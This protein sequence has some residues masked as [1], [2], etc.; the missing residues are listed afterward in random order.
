[1]SITSFVK[2]AI[3]TV[4]KISLP[5][6]TTITD[7]QMKI[8]LQISSSNEVLNYCDKDYFQNEVKEIIARDWSLGLIDIG[9]QNPDDLI[10]QYFINNIFYPKSLESLKESKL[11]D[12]KIAFLATKKITIENGITLIIDHDTAERDIFLKMLEDVST[13]R[14]AKGGAFTYQ[15][16]D[17][18]LRI[19]PEIAAYIFKDLFV[20]T[21]N[22]AQRTK[23][24]TRVHNKTI[25]YNCAAA[26]IDA[27][28]T[29]EAVEAVSWS[30]I[31]PAGFIVNVNDKAAQMLADESVS[32]LAKAAIN[33]ATDASTGEIHLVKS[34][35]ELLE[36]S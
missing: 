7:A 36:D 13:L 16:G 18:A 31:N 26:K 4:I 2:K 27:A 12:L 9:E 5:A 20:A 19:L 6:K 1:M 32:D 3:E 11:E 24:N 23:I 8:S 15:Q 21:L 35:E 34:L 30:F 14:Y 29:H 25:V 33:A 22:N 17:L 10:G 28:A